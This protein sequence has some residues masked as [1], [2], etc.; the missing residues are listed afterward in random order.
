MAR[1]RRFLGLRLMMLAS[2]VIGSCL[3]AAQQSSGPAEPPSTNALS[4][5][6]RDLR[7]Q[8]GELQKVVAEMRSENQQA[9]AESA[10]LRQE[11]ERLR[12]VS[13][14]KAQTASEEPVALEP[15]N[16]AATSGQSVDQQSQKP[17]AER[18]ARLEEEYDLLAG[19][20]DDQYQT[21][22]ESASKY[23]MRLSGIVLMNLFS[24]AGR[25]DNI[26]VP[27]L[28]YGTAPGY[29]SG[30]TG[31][32]LRQSEIGFEVFGPQVAGAKTRAD[33]QLDF[34]GGFQDAPNG[35]NAG[36]ARLRT[37]TMRLDWQNTSV[38]AG[39][40]ALFFSPLSPTSFASL[41]VPP[42]TY[43]GNLW[44]WI[45][46]VRVEHRVSMGEGSSLTFEGG[47]LDPLSGETPIRASYRLP[48]PG[49]ASRAPA[50]GSRVAWNHSLFGQPMVWG[51]G[52]F[53]SRQ[54]YDFGRNLD[55]WA[56]MT[57]LE[58][59]LS[60]Q[61]TLSGKVYRGRGLG[62]LY[63]GIGRSVLFSGDPSSP[64]SQ[65]RGLNSVGGWSQ[66]KYRASTKVEF[67]V[68]YGLDNPYAR[69][70]KAFPFPQSYQ[71]PSLARNSGSFANVIFRPRS[72]LLF[73]AEYRHLK[74]Y[75]TDYG[76][77]S[78]GHVNL[79]MGVLF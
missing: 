49:E 15:G 2:I 12:A 34:G 7:D 43:A 4:D 5:A 44:G 24:N 69:D 50:L 77:N 76:P 74:T 48:G 79:M 17:S 1:K 60:H 32:T 46:Q 26:D 10:A 67:N 55:A 29:S 63:G 65:V 35:V 56:G 72:D 37:G 6:V 39:Q 66:L 54:N 13:S 20:V 14:A 59:P 58:V 22:V 28:A 42:L 19:K 23:R 61:F 21:K 68:A 57:D 38:V 75:T 78:A 18:D 9:R 16:T 51:F 70:L 25:V 64:S 41:T 62:G 31:A 3:S 11:L 52:G 73:S 45:P 53:Y 40:D 8:V 36:L 47:M 30:S 33:L 71:D 27:T